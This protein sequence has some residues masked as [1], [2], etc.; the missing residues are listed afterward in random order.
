MEKETFGVTPP[1]G[2]D[3]PR[4]REWMESLAEEKGWK[5]LEW[6]EETDQHGFPMGRLLGNR[7]GVQDDA[8]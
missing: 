6:V 7:P 1:G 4:F 5:D 8:R 3:S 2:L